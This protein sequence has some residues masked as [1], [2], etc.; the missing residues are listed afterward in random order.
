MS[1][2]ITRNA[3][4]YY[5]LR[6]IAFQLDSENNIVAMADL[7]IY[8]EDRRVIDEDHPATTLEPGEAA[9]FK[10]WV[11]AQLDAYETATGLTRL[12]PE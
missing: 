1:D 8:N 2:V 5:S 3:P 9:A 4:V 12:P 11:L 6:R 10:T 7:A